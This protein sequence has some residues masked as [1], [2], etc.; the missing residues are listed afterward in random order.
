MK[1]ITPH[2]TF[3]G[4]CEEALTFYKE[5]LSGEIVSLER[6]WDNSA[7]LEEDQQKMVKYAELYLGEDSIFASDIPM[8]LSKK[9]PVS[10]VKICIGLDDAE[11]A[12][13]CF[14]NLAKGGFVQ[15]PLHDA[16]DTSKFGE[17]TDKF[18]VQWVIVYVKPDSKK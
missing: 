6:F 11:E 16:A 10:N 12:A 3:A 14:T 13:I 15:T 4:N 8:A 7:G 2:L 18:G 5:S 17:L 9:T 1:T